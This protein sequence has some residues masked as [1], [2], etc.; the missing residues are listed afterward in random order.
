MH[1]IN[2]IN[3]KTLNTAQKEIVRYLNNQI[4]EHQM[5]FEEQPEEL[6]ISKHDWNIMLENLEYKETKHKYLLLGK[7]KIYHV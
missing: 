7:I 5:I 1:E 2:K 4:I 3:L 6:L